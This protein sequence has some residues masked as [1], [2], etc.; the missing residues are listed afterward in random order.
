MTVA[1]ESFLPRMRSD[2]LTSRLERLAAARHVCVL[3][4]SNTQSKKVGKDEK[5]HHPVD[6]RVEPMRDVMMPRLLA[7]TRDEK[8]GGGV[9]VGG[10]ASTPGSRRCDETF[11]RSCRQRRWSVYFFFPM[12]A[13]EMKLGEESNRRS[14]RRDLLLSLKKEK[15]ETGALRFKG[16]YFTKTN[17]AAPTNSHLHFHSARGALS[18]WAASNCRG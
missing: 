8:R 3:P 2:H 11:K 7:C 6:S 4:R 18:E 15:K 14:A 12:A 1:L 17:V 16:L 9:S 10:S 5:R 13:C